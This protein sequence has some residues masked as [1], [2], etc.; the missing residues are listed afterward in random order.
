L[1]YGSHEGGTNLGQLPYNIGFADSGALLILQQ[2]LYT[3]KG[4][5]YAHA[6]LLGQQTGKFYRDNNLS[7]PLGVDTTKP[8]GF[9]STKSISGCICI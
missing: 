9:P 3:L 4:Q 8:F 1:I 5:T 2:F 6:P 7:I